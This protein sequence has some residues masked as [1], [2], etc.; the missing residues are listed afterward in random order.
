MFWNFTFE[1]FLLR[2]MI[3]RLHRMYTQITILSSDKHPCPLATIQTQT[4]H[5][6]VKCNSFTRYVIYRSC[7]ESWYLQGLQQLNADETISI[8]STMHAAS[9]LPV[10]MTDVCSWTSNKWT[11]A[12]RFLL[13]YSDIDVW[14]WFMHNYIGSNLNVPTCDS[15]YIVY[16]NRQP[17]CGSNH[18]WLSRTVTGSGGDFAKMLVVPEFRSTL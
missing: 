9:A 4:G 2:S 5:V 14:R 17:G 12:D 11:K 1:R 3:I 6:T 7:T 10:K 18:V 8:R 15:K 16:S 13:C